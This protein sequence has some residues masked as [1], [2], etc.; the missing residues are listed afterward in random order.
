MKNLRLV[1]LAILLFPTL[2]YAELEKKQFDVLKQ[3]D[4]V[5]VLTGKSYGTNI[6]LV[7]DEKGLVLID[8]MPGTAHLPALDSLVKKISSKP[9][10]YVAN[11]HNHEDH[12]GGNEYFSKLGANVYEPPYLSSKSSIVNKEA[13]SLKE[14]GLSVINVKSH[15]D[16]DNIFFHPKSNVLFVGDVFDNYWHPTFYAG[17]IDGFTKSINA[18]LALGNEN[19]VIV[20]GH[21]KPTNKSV[22]KAFHKNTLIWLKRVSWLNKKKM[23]IE[24]IMEDKQ[25]N[26]LL[27]RFN[28]EK[29][30]EF[31]PEKAFRRF[32]ERSISI[33]SP[34]QS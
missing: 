14:M 8:P 33:V 9:I 12:T 27:Q 15:T 21:G 1:I 18:I 11:T 24:Q 16:F 5:F 13:S 34:S 22:V 17:G 25:I 7:V 4:S 23:S 10:I 20:P 29:R 30:N 31:I 26:E 6:G 32:I 28:T 19:S 2:L 3:N